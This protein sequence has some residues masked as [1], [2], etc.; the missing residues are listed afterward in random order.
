[1]YKARELLGKFASVAS[2]SPFFPRIR[3]VNGGMGN[4]PIFLAGGHPF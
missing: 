2:I 1:M 4:Q 3:Q